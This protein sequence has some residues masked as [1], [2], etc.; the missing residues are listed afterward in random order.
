M[1]VLKEQ[2]F[3]VVKPD[4]RR[5]ISVPFFV[6]R[7][8]SGL[9]IRMDYA[10]HRVTDAKLCAEEI[11]SCLR[12]YLPEEER[13]RGEIRPEDYDP[14]FNFITLSLDC[15]ERYVGCAHRHDP[16]LIVRISEREASPGFDPTPIREG[17]WRVMLHVH[18]VIT[19]QIRCR[20]R[21]WG[22]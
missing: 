1:N 2:T 4:V 5:N 8:F 13:P 22:V 10:P 17:P 7:P 21:I 3:C 19:D 14:L 20:L 6:D 9:V 12:R 18:A 11:E 16:A 15:G